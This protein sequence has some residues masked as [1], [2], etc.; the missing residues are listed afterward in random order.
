MI[1][2][3]KKLS[4][5]FKDDPTIDHYLQ[6]RRDHPEKEIEIAITDGMEWLFFNQK[7][8]EKI[9]IDPMQFAGALDADTE[10]ISEISLRLLKHLIDRKKAE[11]TGKTHL[12]SR[13]EAISDTMVNYMIATMLDAMSWN[14][15]LSI[16]RDL[17]V[18]IRHQLGFGQGNKNSKQLASKEL[19]NNV[20]RTGARLLEQGQTISTRKIA[21][22]LNV[23]ASTISR[24]YPGNTLADKSIELL[25]SM[26]GWSKSETPFADSI[27]KHFKEDRSE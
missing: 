20:L 4:R 21:S 19:K 16:P 12:V 17:I 1:D 18:L 10:A 24:M 6:L 11:R 5:E 26:K 8:L 27:K 25:N 7:L 14:G 23:N 13:N 22:C 3:D 15:E 9:G 2:V